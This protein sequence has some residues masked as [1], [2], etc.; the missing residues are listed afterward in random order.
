MMK[1]AILAVVIGFLLTSC[2]WGEFGKI[3]ITNEDQTLEITIPVEFRN[4]FTQQDAGE[5][6][7]IRVAYEANTENE[8]V[9]SFD[10]LDATDTPLPELTQ[11]IYGELIE[12]YL[13]ETELQLVSETSAETTI[14]GL[15]AV[16]H[17]TVFSAPSS[18]QKL[19]LSLIVVK[20]ETR[21]IEIHILCGEERYTDNREDVFWSVVESFRELES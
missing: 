16:Q 6:S 5:G 17:D 7:R 4:K 12:S 10:R 1:K 9:L 15:P 14:Q 2:S 18:S 11:G 21:N 3:T 19:H 20:G 8:V 13:G